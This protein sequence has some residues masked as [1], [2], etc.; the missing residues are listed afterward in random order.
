MDIVIGD[1]GPTTMSLNDDENKLLDE[2]SI[3]L[4]ERKTVPLKAKPSRPS[5]FAKRTAGPV[6]PNVQPDDGLDL[7]MNPGKHVPAAPPP[8]EEYDGGEEPMDEEDYQQGQTGGGGAQV[9]SEGYKTIEDEKAD[10]LNKISRL[11]KKGFQ[12]SARLNIYSDIEEIRTEYKRITYSIEV[13]RS[14]KFQ[15]RMLVACVTGLEFLNDKFDPFDL[16][17]NGWSQNVMENVEDY[18]G[19]FE[20]LYN[21]YKTKISVAPEVKLIMMVGGSAM[22][23]HLTNSM[24]KAAVPNVSQVMKQNPDLMR[25]MVDAVQRSQQGAGPGANEPPSQGL[26]REMRGPGM[27]FGSLMGMMGPPPPVMTRPGRAE[28]DDVSDI[29]SMDAEDP[30]TREVKL[31]GGEK[32][33]RGPKGKGKKE[34]SL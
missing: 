33:K 4:P 22:M 28:D 15:R 21:K 26:R 20:E 6:V 16:E 1:Q 9:P 25:N 5:P 8:P 23:F 13:D 18:D 24:F 7:F 10:L 32:K 29:V 14:V 19:V 34:V 12:T 27:D 3:Q 2:I 30:D 11:A 17:L 31:D